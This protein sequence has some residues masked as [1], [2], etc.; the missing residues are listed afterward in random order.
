MDRAINRYNPNTDNLMFHSD[1]GAQ[2]SSK[3]F[4]DYCSNNNITQSMSRKGNCWDNA[5]ME[6]FFRSLK[7]ERLNY[8]SGPL[9]IACQSFANHYEVMLS[10]Q[11]PLA[12]CRRWLNWKKWLEMCPRLTDHYTIVG[13]H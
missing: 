3:A 11:Y 10:V 7:T 13:K 2:Y 5:V 9:Y 4:I 8:P 6:R 12:R 1:Q